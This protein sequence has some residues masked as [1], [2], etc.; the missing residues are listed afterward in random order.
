LTASIFSSHEVPCPHNPAERR[1]HEAVVLYE[2]ASE[3]PSQLVVA[4][5]WVLV[6]VR[7][8]ADYPGLG[9]SFAGSTT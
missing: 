2:Q 5:S 9:S 3:A 4:R 1:R 8:D 6:E 7:T